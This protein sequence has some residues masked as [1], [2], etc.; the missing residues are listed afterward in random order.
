MSSFKKSA[1]LMHPNGDIYVFE[2]NN[3]VFKLLD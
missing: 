2:K 3:V 1:T